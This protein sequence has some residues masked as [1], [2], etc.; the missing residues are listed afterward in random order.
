MSNNL[1]VLKKRYVDIYKKANR[2]NLVSVSY[3]S[4]LAPVRKNV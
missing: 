1:S 4:L 3:R 2:S